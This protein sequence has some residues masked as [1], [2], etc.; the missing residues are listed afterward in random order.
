MNRCIIAHPRKKHNC[1]DGKAPRTRTVRGAGMA[2]YVKTQ[3]PLPPLRSIT[4]WLPP[5]TMLVEETTVS[6]ALDWSYGMELQPQL[7]MVL[8][9]LYRVDWTPSARGP[10]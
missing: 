2:N 4:S 1:A 10:A 6:L 7:H 8:F 9:T 5:S 3:L